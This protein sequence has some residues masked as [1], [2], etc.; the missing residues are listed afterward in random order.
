[1]DNEFFLEYNGEKLLKTTNRG[2][3]NKRKASETVEDD[4]ESVLSNG[5]CMSELEEGADDSCGYADPF[6]YLPEECCNMILLKLEEKE[7]IQA[8]W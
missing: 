2:Q 5:S 4:G 1:M 6:S 7:L 3:S 8:A